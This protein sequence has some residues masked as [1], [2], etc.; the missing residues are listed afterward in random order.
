M[1]SATMML[2]VLY[3]TIGRTVAMEKRCVITL[4]TCMKLLMTK[5]PRN[6]AGPA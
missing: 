1:V 4:C 5:E 2:S 3:V 6:T